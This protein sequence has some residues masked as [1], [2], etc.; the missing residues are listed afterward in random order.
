MLG[1]FRDG[2]AIGG[3]RNTER[4]SVGGRNVGARI[5]ADASVVVAHFVLIAARTGSGRHPQPAI[6][7]EATTRVPASVGGYH[8]VLAVGAET[9]DSEN[10]DAQKAEKTGL[11]SC[12]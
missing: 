12:G 9:D 8:R 6:D 11:L 1:R 7:R 5:L 2:A 4:R 3:C 10:Q